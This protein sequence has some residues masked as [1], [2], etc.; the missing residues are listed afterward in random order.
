MGPDAYR[1]AGL[2]KTLQELGH[3]V[4]DLGNLTSAVHQPDSNTGQLHALNETIGWTN[5][6]TRPAE[7]AMTRGLPIFLG[8]DHSLALGTIVGVHRSKGTPLIPSG[9]HA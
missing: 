3:R 9:Y 6:L 2:S 8:D 1:N 5:R 4:E 7:D